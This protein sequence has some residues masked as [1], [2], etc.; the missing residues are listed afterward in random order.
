MSYSS[1]TYRPSILEL[2]QAGNYQ[3]I[4]YWINSLLGPRGV[5]VQAAM[6]RSGCLTLYV[7]FQYPTKRQNGHDLREQIVRFICY[8]LWTLNSSAIQ[9]VRIVARVV[10]RPNVLWRQSVRILTPANR[11]RLQPRPGRVPT[12]VQRGLSW[13]HFQILRS[14]VIGRFVVASFFLC[15]WLYYWEVSGLQTASRTI[16]LVSPAQASDA[17][18]LDSTKQASRLA[19]PK[20]VAIE[21]S[22]AVS[23]GVPEAF[24]GNV[25]HQIATVPGKKLI[26]LTF[27]DG[28]WENTTEDVLEILEQYRIKATFFLVGQQI[29]A[30]PELAKKI[31]AAGHALGNHTWTH[32]MQNVDETTAAQEIGNTKR[33]IYEL[34]GIQAQLFRPP[35]GNL[36]GRLVPYAQQQKDAVVLWSTDSSDYYASAPVIIDNVL[37]TA[38]PGGIVLLHDGG[39]DRRA[40]VQALPPI[41]EG[42][43]RQGYQFVTLPELMAAQAKESVASSSTAPS[44]PADLNE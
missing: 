11:S 40:T 5:Y 3:A 35:G 28:P 7:D 34:T 18:G 1:P 26:A 43:Q 21:G 17:I 42:L 23:V 33:L 19:L 30:R 10:G 31:A 6:S 20:S 38:Q 9:D 44:T 37:S 39:G 12:V 14:V 27:D 41:I 13:L 8:R 32:P 15:Y 22:F 36:S 4:A 29:Q 16:A 2:A 24:R 25:I